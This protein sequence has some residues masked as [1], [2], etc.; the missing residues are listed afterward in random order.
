[1][2]RRSKQL[3]VRF[4]DE[5]F[6]RIAAAAQAMQMTP[7]AWLRL[8]ALRSLDRLR[9]IPRWKPPPTIRRHRATKLSVRLGQRGGEQH[10]E[11]LGEKYSQS[12]ERK[13]R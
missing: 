12:Q 4:S 8:Q 6:L 9:E 2:A 10:Y 7:T 3:G 5:E 11:P 1:M 13:D